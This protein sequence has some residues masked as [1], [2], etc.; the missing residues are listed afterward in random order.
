[1]ER[2]GHD[3]IDH[4]ELEQK[5]T[6]FDGRMKELDTYL[7]LADK[8]VDSALA[9][10]EEALRYDDADEKMSQAANRLLADLISFTGFTK[11][12][13][14]ADNRQPLLKFGPGGDYV[15]EVHGEDV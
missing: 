7:T 8:V 4:R 1:M 5:L 14:S 15:T 2:N 9:L 6:A 11:P 3:N 10:H 13:D 12:A